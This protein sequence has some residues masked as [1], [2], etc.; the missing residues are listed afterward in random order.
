MRTS[1]LRRGRNGDTGSGGDFN[2]LLYTNYTPLSGSTV[3]ITNQYSP[4]TGKGKY[5]GSDY[6]DLA[7]N[8]TSIFFEV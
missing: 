5:L 4:L 7:G 6:T 8:Q 3:L 2:T 1:R